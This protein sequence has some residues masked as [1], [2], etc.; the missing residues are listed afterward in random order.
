MKR[1]FTI[2]ATAFATQIASFG[3]TTITAP[4]ATIENERPNILYIMCDDM[5]YGDLG[6]YGQRLIATPNIDRLSA[7]G[8]RFTQ[9]YAGSPVSA[10]SR[11]AFM[12]GQHTGHT[13][14][15][16]NR[17]HWPK[18]PL[19]TYGKNQDY[20]IVG[21]EPYDTAHVILPEILKDNGYATGL[22]G[23]WAGG[24]EGSAS[25]PDKRG[26]DEFYGYV[27]QYQAHLYFPNFLNSYSRSKGDTAV[28]RIVLDQNIQHDM[29]GGDYAKRQQYSADLI[30]R[31]ALA[32][33]DKQSSAQPFFGIFT[34]TLPHAEL[35]QP[36]DSIVKAYRHRFSSESSYKGNASSRYN[37]TTE[38]HTQF[39]AMVTRLDAQVGE[40]MA[41]LEEK[42]LARNTIVIFTSDNGP[43]EEGGADPAFFNHDGL[44]RGTKRSTLEGG[45]RVP[46]IVH[47]PEHIKGGQVSDQQ[48]VFYDLMPTFCD[49]AGI[50]NYQSRY[51]N[52]RLEK[53]YFDG[54]SILPTLTGKGQQMQHDHLYW[55]FHETDMI[56]VRRGDWK[57]VVRRGKCALYNLAN[58]L[59][60]DHDLATQHPDI[61]E[62]L[63]VII[64]QEHTDNPFFKVTL[65]PLSTTP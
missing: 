62:Q 59:H 29:I 24:Y 14:V 26:I 2:S 22:F 58:D 47:W 63:K 42:G 36:D 7:Q 56:A 34:Y 11:A 49:I 5:G 44:L 57:L 38:G 18:S 53:D 35:S 20:A 25:T 48:V 9:A 39:A 54:V 65:P 30:H 52:P 64:H 41:K 27:C 28:R 43:H 4:Q 21:Q 32:W 3:Q 51:R 1:L 10:P 61:V 40:I 6:C 17:E 19:I 50:D 15:R 33:L 13:H 45:I 60:E 16:G 55:E 31:E 8:M 12:T 37:S 46:F 23:K